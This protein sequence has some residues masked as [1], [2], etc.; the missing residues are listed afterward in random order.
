MSDTP[1]INSRLAQFR[2]AKR[3]AILERVHILQIAADAVGAGELNEELKEQA[4]QEAHRLKGLLGSIG[5]P[6]GSVAAAQVESNLKE[7]PSATELNALI[8]VI[9]QV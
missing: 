8:A 5:F 9:K 2:I 3:P 6:E 1:D 7:S 4:M